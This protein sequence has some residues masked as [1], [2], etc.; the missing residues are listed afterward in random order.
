MTRPPT[1]RAFAALAA[2]MM[3]ALSAGCAA[4]P[5]ATPSEAEKPITAVRVVPAALP[6]LPAF[7]GV[8]SLK[9]CVNSGFVS[10]LTPPSHLS[11]P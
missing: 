4:R 2:A 8:I 7:S 9:Y 10:S 3:L 5:P 1:S 11:L 6:H